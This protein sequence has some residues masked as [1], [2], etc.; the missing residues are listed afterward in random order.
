[1]PKTTVPIPT[2]VLVTGMRH[3]DGEIVA[4]E[5]YAVAEACGQS[6]E[7][8]R[9]CLRRLVNEGLYVQHGK[10]RSARYEAT[11]AGVAHL[12]TS[13]ARTRTA[14]QQ[15]A[16]GRGWDRMWR[17]VAFAVPEDRRAARD[18]LR[19]RLVA[20]GGAALQGGVYVSPHP[21]GDTVRHEAK[22][23]DLEEHLSLATT[24]DLEIGGVRDP[25]LLARMLWPIDEVARAYEAFI[26]QHR[27]V[28]E[29][30]EEM[31]R[32]KERFRDDHFL[33]FAFSMAVAMTECT[34]IDPLLPP[35]LLPR[36]WPGR[37]ARELVLRSR[38][39]ALLVREAQDRPA[40][41]HLYDL[42]V[43]GLS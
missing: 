22:R 23:L 7:Q 19:D 27:Q 32:K 24:D 20:L 33:P 37:S 38:R 15:D 34:R 13:W 39:L 25:R 26:A 43:E 6:S 21:W 42:M 2:R 40:L 3:D 30:L 36:P 17:L 41:F 35:E 18:Q 1:M 10:G 9:S 8:V 12:E 16:A 11:E 5:L 4:S 14:Y 29:D 31:R 28:P